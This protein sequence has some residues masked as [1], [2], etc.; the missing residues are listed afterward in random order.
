MQHLPP[1]IQDLAL[2]LISAAG[3]TLLCRWLK[4]PVVLGYIL[5]GILVGPHTPFFTTVTEG[6]SVR[7]WGE[8]GVIFLLFGL[9]L[10]F[11]F[12]KLLKMGF[13]VSITAAVEVILMLGVGF[14]L[15]RALGWSNMDSVFLGGILSISST[16]IVVRALSESGLKTKSFSRLIFGILIVEDIAAVVL[17]VVLSTYAAQNA[18]VGSE[19]VGVLVRI[20]FFMTL[21]FVVGVFVLPSALK[22]I[23]KHLSDEILL[24]IAVGLCLGMAVLATHSG[25]SAALG[26]FLMGSL[27]AETVE[28]ERVEKI[29]DPVRSLFSAVFFVSVGMML[30]P[31]VL[32]EK[33]GL[34][35][36]ISGV[37][38]VAKTLS[39]TFAAVLT[40]NPVRDAVRSGMSLSQI[41]EFSFIIATLG[42]KLHVVDSVLYSITVSISILTAFT[43]P[44]AVRLS[45]PLSERLERWMDSSLPLRW[46]EG[47]RSYQAAAQRI[48][49]EGDLRQVLKSQ[50][51]QALLN[52][53]VVIA[54]GVLARK[55]L[56]PDW[57]VSFA[58]DTISPWL[59]SAVAV[60]LT[61]FVAAPFL[62]AVAFSGFRSATMR[63]YFQK[64]G[65]RVPLILLSIVRA[66]VAFV[67]LGYLLSRFLPL[68]MGIFLVI[69]TVAAG[70]FLLSERLER[71]Y[72]AFMSRFLLNLS[73]RDREDEKKA[74]PAAPILLPWDSHLEVYKV[75]VDSPLVGHTLGA[76]GVRERFAVTIA[77]IERDKRRIPA[78]PRDTV[79][80]PGDQLHVLGEEAHLVAF[81]A[82]AEKESTQVNDTEVSDPFHLHPIAL[83]E[84]SPWISKTIRECGIRESL[85]GLVVGVERS[86]A[87]HL[88]PAADWVLVRGDLVWVVGNSRLIKDWIKN[89]S[90]KG[91]SPV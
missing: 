3:A 1:L 63:N 10:E 52:S 43:T 23:K 51:A 87:R 26:A 65:E 79:I 53:V 31:A 4:Q 76:L 49:G 9:G 8:I 55:F 30:D 61:I 40:G 32:Q 29:L 41:G 38:I 19:V 20:G 83:D 64:P 58:P 70:F 45:G 85:Q 86:G 54:L 18:L 7:A 75:S 66:M 90:Q 73:A 50:A 78:P 89:R 84:S 14:G 17:L 62:W 47:L 77:M 67:L 2:I 56:K 68:R 15:G 34:I 22:K 81:R 42:V 74:Q 37:L 69:G 57:I 88:N 60:F 21:W 16:S 36:L 44:H 35:L 12:K 33:A 27:L 5:A 91:A 6:E 48:S 46:R 80:Y 39:V 25:L 13:S 11:S 24:V 71:V 59:A 82:E 72:E 28:A